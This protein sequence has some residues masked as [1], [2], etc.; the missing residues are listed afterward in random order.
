MCFPFQGSNGDAGTL[1]ETKW[2]GLGVTFR[3]AA[4][5]RKSRRQL[6]MSFAYTCRRWVLKAGDSPLFWDKLYQLWK[7]T[8]RTPDPLKIQNLL[9][10]WLIVSTPSPCHRIGS[11]KI[12]LR[13]YLDLLSFI[14]IQPFRWDDCFNLPRQLLV[15]KFTVG[16]A[17][18]RNEQWKNPCC[19]WLF[20]VCWRC[21]T[22]LLKAF[23]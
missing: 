13:T 23:D 7:V 1:E 3:F 2:K 22:R 19:F 14:M 5:V 6:G 18:H 4:I 20:V 10:V 21:A 11:R 16:A 12:L 17:G 9:Y 8:S 15:Y